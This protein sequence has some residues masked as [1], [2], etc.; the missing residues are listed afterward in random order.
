MVTVEVGNRNTIQVVEVVVRVQAVRPQPHEPAV[1]GNELITAYPMER[2][3][4]QWSVMLITK[5]EN[6]D[7]CVRV[8]FDDPVTRQ[9]RF[10]TGAVEPA[11]GKR[12]MLLLS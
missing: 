11:M 3:D 6:H 1:M 12:V 2:P 10:F 5:D 4:G 7:H 8:A 9:T